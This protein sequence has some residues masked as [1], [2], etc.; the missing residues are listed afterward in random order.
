MTPRTDTLHL[1]MGGRRVRR[2]F[3]LPYLLMAPVALY[4]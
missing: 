1:E 4:I 3:L 2:P